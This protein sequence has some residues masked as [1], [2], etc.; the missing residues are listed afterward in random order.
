MKNLSAITLV[1]FSCAAISQQPDALSVSEA[2]AE[3][4]K[5]NTESSEVY[6]EISALTSDKY[7]QE[8]SNCNSVPVGSVPCGGPA[9]HIVYSTFKGD[10]FEQ[11]LKELANRTQI[12]DGKKNSISQAI[13]IC[14]YNAAYE[15][16]CIENVCSETKELETK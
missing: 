7:C 14:Q 4:A 13:G 9:G 8:D 16:A 2:E 15:L 1:L 11:T 5:I 10:D 6:A 12:L 3:L